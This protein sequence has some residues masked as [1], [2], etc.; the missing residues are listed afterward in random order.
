MNPFPSPLP[1][2]FPPLSFCDAVFPV[3]DVSWPVQI[4]FPLSVGC[5]EQILPFTPLFLSVTWRGIV[6]SPLS[7]CPLGVFFPY[8]GGGLFSAFA[9]YQKLPTHLFSFSVLRLSPLL[10]DGAG[11]SRDAF[12]CSFPARDSPA[13]VGEVFPFDQL[14]CFPHPK[15]PPWFKDKAQ[16]CNP[17]SEPLFFPVEFILFFI[18]GTS[19]T[20]FS[21]KVLT[22][23]P[24][25]SAR[26]QS[27]CPRPVVH[28]LRFGCPAVQTGFPHIIPAAFF[29][30]TCRSWS[31]FFRSLGG[32]S[33]L[34]RF[35]PVRSF[36][37]RMSQLTGLVRP[38][39]H[40][41][42]SNTLLRQAILFFF[43]SLHEPPPPTAPS[44][45]FGSPVL[46]YFCVP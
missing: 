19:A 38:L 23:C 31:P 15:P 4:A 11:A 45:L 46:Y 10:I 9:I 12:P 41:R 5:C 7:R 32:V 37:P 36:P 25:R 42:F 21:G 24:I 16:D 20:L 35:S 30:L 1:P 13:P 18:F 2:H 28:A 39:A 17:S 44:F 27:F 33:K 34:A 43:D 6:I 22:P 8:T 3:G 40:M 29:S 26:W 14:R